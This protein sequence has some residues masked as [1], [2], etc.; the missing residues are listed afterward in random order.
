LDHLLGE[1]SPSVALGFALLVREELPEFG[2]SVLPLIIGT[3]IIFEI[4]GPFIAR[5]QLRK[6][7]ELSEGPEK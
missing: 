7:G 1:S 2:E 4:A 6:A 5:W 3:T